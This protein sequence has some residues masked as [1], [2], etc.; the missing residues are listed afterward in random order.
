MNDK[1]RRL[2]DSVLALVEENARETR[3]SA[4]MQGRMDDGGASRIKTQTRFYQYK[5]NKIMPV[6]RSSYLK[7]SCLCFDS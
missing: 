2:L 3:E 5:K 7:E 4:G 6:E 1:E